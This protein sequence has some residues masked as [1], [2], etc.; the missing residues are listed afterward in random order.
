MS[1]CS[2]A[3]PGSGRCSRWLDG[4]TAL[5][6]GAGTLERAGH[7]FLGGFKDP[8]DLAGLEAQDVA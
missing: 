2:V 3:E 8:G 6:G 7:R 4:G 1:S 5:Q